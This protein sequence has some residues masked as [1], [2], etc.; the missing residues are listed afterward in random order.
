VFSVEKLLHIIE[1]SGLR[2]ETKAILAQMKI[3]KIVIQRQSGSCAL[4]LQLPRELPAA[5]QLAFCSLV[6]N[7]LPGVDDVS[8]SLECCRGEVSLETAIGPGREAL[9][10]RIDQ[11][12][13]GLRSWLGVA[14]W[15]CR[16][17]LQRDD[18]LEHRLAIGLPNQLGVDIC[19]QKKLASVLP[20]VFHEHYSLCVRVELGVAAELA[21]EIQQQLESI[22]R[23]QLSSLGEGGDKAAA[24][25][26]GAAKTVTE[27][28]LGKAIRGE[29][30]PLEKIIE[31]EKSVTVCGRVFGLETRV[32][33]SGRRLVTFNLTDLTDSIGVKIFCDD[34]TP[35]SLGEM[36]QEGIW[37]KARGPVQIDRY[38]QELTLMAYDINLAATPGRRDEAAEK[39]VELHLHSKMSALDSVADLSQVVRQAAQWGH[40]A[41]A[42]TDHG[43]VQAFPE[44]YDLGQKYGIKIIY[45]VEGYLIDDEADPTPW[46]K[47]RAKHVIIMVR[48]QAGLLNLYKLISISHLEYYH[49]TPR[50]LKSVLR[51]H[52]EGLVIG[53]ACEAGELFQAVRRNESDAELARIASFY[54][55]LEVQ[56]LGNNEFMIRSGEA[57]GREDL[58]RFNRRIIDLG[59]QLDKPVVATGDV[60]FLNPEDAIYRQ[61]LMAGKGFEDNTQ[62]PLYLRTTEEMLAEFS[63]LDQAT[64]RRIVIESPRQL[65]EEIEE[66]LPIPKDLY[67]P[68][69]EG[70]ED[71]VQGMTLET[72]REMYGDPLPEIVQ[73][74]LDKELNSIISNGFSVLY[75]IAHKLV[76]KSND[77]G[78]LVGSRG[79]V[80]SSLVATMMGITEVNPLPPHYLCSHCRYSEFITDGSVGSGPD[81]TDKNCPRCGSPLGKEGHDIPFET[82]LGFKGDKTPDIDLNFSGDYQP[83]AH[84]Y[85]EELF[86][87]NHV[88]RAGTIATIADKTAYGF[89]KGFLGDSNRVAREAEVSRLVSGCTGVKRTTGQHPGGLMVVPKNLDIH[90]FSP[91]QRPADDVKSD[92]ITTHFDY[93]SISSRLVKLDILGHDDPTAIKMLEDLTGVDAKRIRLDDRETISLFSGVEALG[94]KTEEIRSVVGTYA[95]PEFG[96]RFVRQMLEDTRPKTFSELV[97][98]SGFSH[99]TDVWLNNAQDLIKAG[100]CR[101]S[102]AI[103]TRDDIMVYLMQRGMEPVVAF[104]I[105]EDVRKGKGVKPDY[106]QA[107]RGANIPE[108][109]IASCQ[110]IK[111]MFP[112]AHATAYVTMAFRIAWFK[113]NYPEAFYATFFSVRADEFDAE[114]ILKG[115]NA[116][117]QA[118]EEIEKKGNEASTKEKNS[119]TILEVALE[120]YLRGL[121]IL[122]V[123]LAHSA[124]DRFQ[125]RSG[126][127]LMPFNALP[128]LGSAAAQNLVEA[129]QERPFLSRDDIRQRARTPKPVMELLAALGS[130]DGL[131]ESSQMCLF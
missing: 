86:G 113:V 44:A 48:T 16:G 33:K 84:K 43:V 42:I 65:A 31:E 129:R 77:D 121:K 61:I 128:G 131:P 28:I 70:A 46:D 38:S 7:H 58:I 105:M 27:I 17:S 6:K 4:Q 54:D 79:S 24:R 10:A 125:I 40:P 74:Q 18:V 112:K 98:I 57:A 55:F 60:H 56:P 87:K 111:Y 71:Q 52:R 91:I 94:V 124:A 103:S 117:F 89:V 15:Q 29:A 81:L 25:G 62:G 39:R 26:D 19:R 53:S 37:V 97:R 32:L 22:D 1:R 36:L 20:L 99:G 104:K 41:V 118:I 126:G 14:E 8:L 123:D 9:L 122:P 23:H 13:P 96:T 3:K 51:Q 93:H 45:G 76:K 88:F 85:V 63:Y 72:A 5:E 34:K 68:E 130:L 115:A 66:I 108:W 102:D 114:V 2:E 50:L 64:A 49:R 109:Y 78:Y 67:P 110:K 83:R 92:T 90:Q 106:E 116:V 21:G 127:I 47:Q 101:L 95:I 11:T 107:M 69:I 120:M 12:V 35:A 100:T 82:F 73:K 75:L 119:M 80:G 30:T 59:R